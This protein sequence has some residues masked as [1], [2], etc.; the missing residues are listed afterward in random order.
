MGAGGGA[1]Q[2]DLVIQIGG[3]RGS[4]VFNFESGAAVN[5]ITDAVNLV[6]DATGVS[7]SFDYVPADTKA[8]LTLNS[9]SYGN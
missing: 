7:A 2:A 9:T 5:Q 4:E 6:S 1:I 3:D 8:T